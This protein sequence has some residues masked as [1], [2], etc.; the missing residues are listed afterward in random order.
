MATKTKPIAEDERYSLL[1]HGMCMGLLPDK[2]SRE[3]ILKRQALAE[4]LTKLTGGAVVV[5]FEPSTFIEDQQRTT[6]GKMFDAS[7]ET[8]DQSMWMQLG[9]GDLG[10][11][12][13]A[14]LRRVGELYFEAADL[15]E[16]NLPTKS[17][18]KR[19][20]KSRKVG[21]K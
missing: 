14:E 20:G 21:A 13:V 7:L 4:R 12:L 5:D 17:K 2:L 8:E 6:F 11:Q 16:K 19:A 18:A 15:A 1:K 9:K 10:R 3:T